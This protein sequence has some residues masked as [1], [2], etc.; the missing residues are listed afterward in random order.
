MIPPILIKPALR[1]AQAQTAK[2][3]KECAI[4]GMIIA[5]DE[6]RDESR[7]WGASRAVDGLS[8]IDAAVAQLRVSWPNAGAS[9]NTAVD[10]HTIALLS[11]CIHWLA[12]RKLFGAAS[13]EAAIKNLYWKA[14]WCYSSDYYARQ[15]LVRLSANNGIGVATSVFDVDADRYGNP[16]SI[17]GEENYTWR[18]LPDRPRLL[19]G[20][21]RGPDTIYLANGFQPLH[22]TQPTQYQPWFDGHNGGDTISLTTDQNLAI[23]ASLASTGAV[24]GAPVWLNSL[25]TASGDYNVSGRSGERIRGFAYEIVRLGM[26]L[27]VKMTHQTPGKEETWLAIPN[28]CI[29]NWWVV[30]DSQH[31]FGPLPFGA[32]RGTA[33]VGA[34]PGWS[35]QRKQLA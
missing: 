10:T 11:A 21:T 8:K 30:H 32:P 4:K 7:R 22:L 29:A 16:Y 2:N 27:S 14:A 9:N 18:M 28:S 23:N 24:T 20:E 19:H 25:L 1:A 3:R 12:G 34:A 33:P 31:T 5:L 15:A 13:R 35:S 6:F 26:K 17:D